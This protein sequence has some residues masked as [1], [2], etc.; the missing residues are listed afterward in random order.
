MLPTAP[1]IFLFFGGDVAPSDGCF[2]SSNSPEY[3]GFSSVASGASSDCLG[4]LAGG[5]GFR[6]TSA[7]TFTI[8]SSSSEAASS[9]SFAF[10]AFSSAALALAAVGE[11]SALSAA[12]SSSLSSRSA[13]GGF[14]NAAEAPRLSDPPRPRPP[15][16]TTPRENLR[17]FGDAAAAAGLSR[18]SPKTPPRMF[19]PRLVGSPRPRWHVPL[20]WFRVQ[21]QTMFDDRAEHL[22]EPRDERVTR[23][24]AVPP[25]CQHIRHL[26]SRAGG[27][28][29]L[30]V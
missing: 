17:R 5:E 22:R 23:G 26:R 14:A 2:F 4:C 8:C 25:R 7:E 18:S 28:V 24:F 20:W 13:V 9:D 15:V 3:V 6:A 11:G 27:V 21:V 1:P 10:L 19:G 12:S 30:H 29:L 16:E